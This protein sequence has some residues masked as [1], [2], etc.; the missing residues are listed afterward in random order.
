[1]PNQSRFLFLK[2][3]TS[4]AALEKTLA[5]CRDLIT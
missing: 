4:T 5:K 1:M 3:N 2:S